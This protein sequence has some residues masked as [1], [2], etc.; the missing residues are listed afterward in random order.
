MNQNYTCG[1]GETLKIEKVT[2]PQDVANIIRFYPVKVLVRL[3]R[4]GEITEAVLRKRV[5]KEYLPKELK[6]T[7]P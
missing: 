7:N 6:E 1:C 5:K 4:N 3:W 2:K